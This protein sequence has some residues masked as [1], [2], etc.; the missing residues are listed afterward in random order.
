MTLSTH[1]GPADSGR[2]L[3]TATA[4]APKPDWRCP[5]CGLQMRGYL[6]R[7]LTIGC[8]AKRP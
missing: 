4:A 6:I 7:C 1:G 5:S 8:N 3:R 2:K